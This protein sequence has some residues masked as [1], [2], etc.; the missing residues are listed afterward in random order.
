MLNYIESFCLRSKRCS[1]QSL[2][3][4]T[5]AHRAELINTVM[6]TSPVK[7]WIILLLLSFFTYSWDRERHC[8]R[9]Y[10]HNFTHSPLVS[11]LIRYQQST[12][13]IADDGFLIMNYFGPSLSWMY[14]CTGGHFLLRAGKSS[15]RQSCL[16]YFLCSSSNLN[17]KSANNFLQKVFLHQHLL[18]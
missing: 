2:P 7:H 16:P 17:L 14:R 11:P 10:E 12:L 8:V 9:R 3:L 6:D 13:L 5:F 1:F 4:T 15:W 18:C